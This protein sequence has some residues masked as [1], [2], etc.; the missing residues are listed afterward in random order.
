MDVEI[1]V[2]YFG[3]I[4]KDKEIE[5]V[6]STIRVPKGRSTWTGN[7][8]TPSVGFNDG[9]A[10]ILIGGQASSFPSTFYVE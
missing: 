9:V 2:E 8:P 3:R 10:Q 1:R 4:L 7:P 6:R 5:S